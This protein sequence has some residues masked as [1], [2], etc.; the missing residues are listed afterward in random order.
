MRNDDLPEVTFYNSPRDLYDAAMGIVVSSAEREEYAAALETKIAGMED[1]STGNRST[2][3]TLIKLIRAGKKDTNIRVMLATNVPL[4]VYLRK[5]RGNETIEG[6]AAFKK[7][8]FNYYGILKHDILCPKLL[9][10]APIWNNKVGNP[11]TLRC[12]IEGVL[13]GAHTKKKGME[14]YINDYMNDVTRCGKP[15]ESAYNSGQTQSSSSMHALAAAGLCLIPQQGDYRV[16][17][18]AMS[19]YRFLYGVTD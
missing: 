6:T 10:S 13:N 11:G 1:I 17:E 19:T 5:M 3:N 9:S 16:P 15:R 12:A 18:S 7:N 2:A 14:A 8:T 4:N